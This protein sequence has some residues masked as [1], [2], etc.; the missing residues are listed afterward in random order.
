[1]THKLLQTGGRAIDKLHGRLFLKLVRDYSVEGCVRSN[2]R[3]VRF[4]IQSMALADVMC[5]SK[6][7]TFEDIQMRVL[8]RFSR[9]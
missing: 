6:M 9:Q 3:M 8:E 7:H 1:M 5:I 4:A 2:I